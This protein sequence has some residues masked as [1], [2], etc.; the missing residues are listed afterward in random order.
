MPSV[1]VVEDEVK[2]AGLL[3]CY[4]KAVKS[5]LPLDSACLDKAR[6][7]FDGVAGCAPPGG[8]AAAR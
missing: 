6:C 4:E 8:C 3:K 1:L 2:M 7:K 5:G